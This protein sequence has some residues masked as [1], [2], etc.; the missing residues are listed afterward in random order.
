MP[1]HADDVTQVDVEATEL[2]RLGQEL[3]LPAAVD[4]VEEDELPHVPP[5]HDSARERVLCAGRLRLEGLRLRPDSSDLL[6]VGKAVRSPHDRASLERGGSARVVVL[7]V[8][9]PWPAHSVGLRRIGL[10]VRIGRQLERRCSAGKRPSG[11]ADGDEI[12]LLVGPA[13]LGRRLGAA[14]TGNPAP[15]GPPEAPETSGPLLHAGS[16]GQGS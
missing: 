3:D 16:L 1:T 11:R 10:R 5:A 8:V 2:V 6:P 14:Q 4:E 7:V 15:S 12:V 13:R 9:V